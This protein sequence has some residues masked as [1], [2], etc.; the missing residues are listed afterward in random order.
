[1]VGAEEALAIGLVD[2]VVP[3]GE[4]LRRRG[5]TGTAVRD[6]PGSGT[7]GGK[8]AIDSS[9]EMDLQRGLGLESQLFSGLFATDDR[10]EG[11]TAFVEKR[12][13]NFTGR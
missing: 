11:M 9:L 8:L 7:A 3:S 12:R 5:G 10:R 2:R 6:R 1:M 13:P 4:R